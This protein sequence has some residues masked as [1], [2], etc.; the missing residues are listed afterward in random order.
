MTAQCRFAAGSQPEL[1]AYVPNV[2]F[3]DLGSSAAQVHGAPPG[4]A[5]SSPLPPSTVL[6]LALVAL[7]DLRDEELHLNYRCERPAKPYT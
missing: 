5:A 6:G 3:G 2:M 1:R 7:S 4:Q